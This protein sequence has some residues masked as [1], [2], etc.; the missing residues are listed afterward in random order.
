MISRFSY[1][2]LII[3]FYCSGL[4]NVHKKA[5]YSKLNSFEKNKIGIF[6]VDRFLLIFRI[7]LFPLK[8]KIDHSLNEDIVCISD[9]QY[10]KNRMEIRKYKIKQLNN[11]SSY[12]LFEEGKLRTKSRL[13]FLRIFKLWCFD[14]LVSLLSLID[15]HNYE[16]RDISNFI[17]EKNALLIKKPKEIHIFYMSK[18]EKY[19]LSSWNGINIKKFIHF[20]NSPLCNKKI[21]YYNN[22]TIVVSGKRQIEEITH[23]TKIGN[24]V[25]Q[26]VIIVNNGNEFEIFLNNFNKNE[27]YDVGFFSEGYWMRDKNEYSIEDPKILHK[28]L[29]NQKEN[30]MGLLEKELFNEC[31]RVVKKNNLKLSI[32]LHPCEERMIKKG[33]NSPFLDYINDKSVFLGEKKNSFSNIYECKIAV[34]T[35]PLSS[36][37]LDCYEINKP[38]ICVSKKVLHEYESNNQIEY[39]DNF[40]SGIQINNLKDLEKKIRVTLRDTLT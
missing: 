16:L 15:F 25:L 28:Y 39:S 22:I 9:T 35:S 7:A 2:D 21:G 29:L 6:F 13:D 5:V 40:Y 8:L 34:V 37:I 19:L 30:N 12:P 17:N 14:F 27:R 3:R 24:I 1:I 4:N 31:L 38:I 11:N 20:S 32:Y 18:A 23:H 36:I 10:N 33:I 26:D